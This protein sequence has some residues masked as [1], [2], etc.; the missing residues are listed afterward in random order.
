MDPIQSLKQRAADKRDKAI[1][2]AQAEYRVTIR[3][4]KE[5]ATSLPNSAQLR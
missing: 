3:Q 5:L 4:L 1:K 2:A